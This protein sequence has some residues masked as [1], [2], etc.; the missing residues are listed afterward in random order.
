MSK[1]KSFPPDWEIVPTIQDVLAME[2]IVKS[3]IAVMWA[4]DTEFSQI[5]EI[6]EKARSWILDAAT[7]IL[8]IQGVMDSK[9]AYH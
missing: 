8:L 9:Q 5:W 1:M 4:N 6:V 2:Q 3:Q 7:A